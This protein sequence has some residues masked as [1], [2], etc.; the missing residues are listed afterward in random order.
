MGEA[1][2]RAVHLAAT[3]KDWGLSGFTNSGGRRACRASA[4]ATSKW[5]A[6]SVVL[7]RQTDGSFTRK[8]IAGTVTRSTPRRHELRKV[9]RRAQSR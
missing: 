9:I 1:K 6:V 8:L 4:R 3:G 7:E 5:L 2:R